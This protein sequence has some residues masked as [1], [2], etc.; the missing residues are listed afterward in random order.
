M[1]IIEARNIKHY[2][3]DKLL[4]DL[5]DIEIYQ[6]ERIGLIGANGSG[7]STL[8]H[9]LACQLEPDQGHVKQHKNVHLM[10][11]LKD[12]IAHK[13]GG[14]VTQK[15][16][17]EALQINASLLLADEPTTHL[18][19]MHIEWLENHL[20]A[21]QG[22]LLL[23]AHDRAFL[24]HLCTTIW[25][26]H[27]GKI[28]VYSGNY[29]DYVKQKDEEKQRQRIDYE[30]YSSKKKQLEE[31]LAEK[32]KRAYQIANPKKDKVEA[33][34]AKPY[35]NKKSK[36]MEQTAK[37]IATRIDK[38]EK[39]EK[40]KEEQSIKMDLPEANLLKKQIIIRAEHIAGKVNERELWQNT[41]FF[42]RGGDKV[43]ITGVNGC[44][45]TTLVKML[46]QQAEGIRISPAVKLGYFS[47][48]LSVLETNKTILQNVQSTSKQSETFIR[49]VLARLRF[50]RDDVNKKVEVLSGGERVKVAFAKLF[51]SDVNMLLLDEPTNF[52]DI[53][54]VQALEELLK[55]YAGT[56]IFVSHDRRFIEQI[57]T[58]QIVI[59]D[60][61]LVITDI[62][63]SSHKQSRKEKSMQHELEEKLMLLDIKL[64]EVLGRL[65]IEPNEQLE[66]QY[67]DLLREKRE[68]Q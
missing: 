54:A 44:G 37:A 49:I 41:T 64:S 2:I 43:A 17:Q 1:L 19:T 48:D 56:I 10:P 45:K 46:L 9:I 21:W 34:I 11:Q 25:E 38:L 58:R 6:G 27:E 22:A 24:D 59:A 33:G 13:S 31:A 8:L 61:K 26:L 65:S 47:Q 14:E 23:V 12:A 36:K 67:K 16:I 4:L 55:D 30:K 50:F 57:A 39:V 20:Q 62:N 7:K 18:D 3:Q 29:S 66:Q 51:V 63:K 52:L 5:A 35:Y 15:Y 42:I 60:K 53:N 28:K 40:V 32:V 68:M